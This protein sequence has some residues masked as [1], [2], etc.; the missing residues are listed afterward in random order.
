[1]LD[2]IS[3]VNKYLLTKITVYA[4]IIQNV[5]LNIGSEELICRQDPSRAV[6]TRY[7]DG[8][9]SGSLNFSY[10]AKSKDQKKARQQL[11]AIVNAL[12]FSGLTTISDGLL[13]KIEVVALPAYVSK[14]ESG[15]HIFTASM[16][17]EYI[18]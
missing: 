5:F 15:E 11:D 3:E 8:R 7:F 14:T 2:I 12:D 4:P 17:L 10:Y 9:R 16:K 1:M 18:N 13:V 6:E